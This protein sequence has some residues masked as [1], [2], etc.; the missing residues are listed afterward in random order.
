VRS[1]CSCCA[2]GRKLAEA[3]K[4]CRIRCTRGETG[5]RRRLAA[6]VCACVPAPDDVFAVPVLFAAAGLVPVALVVFDGGFSAVP[7]DGLPTAGAWGADAFPVESEVA[8]AGGAELGAGDFDGEACA[9]G[10]CAVSVQMSGC[11]PPTSPPTTPT[12]STTH[13]NLRPKRTTLS[14]IVNRYLRCAIVEAR[15]RARDLVEN[16]FLKFAP[17][18]ETSSSA[19]LRTNSS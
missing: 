8:E 14:L 13:Q 17:M 18:I 3:T 6:A 11:A 16:Y 2:M 4:A 7:V 9:A 19:R 5:P 12:V 15:S 10:V 1:C